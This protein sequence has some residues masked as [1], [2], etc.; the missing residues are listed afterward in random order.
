MTFYKFE[1]N[2]LLYNRIKTYPQT[3][4]V[5]YDG[6]TYYNNRAQES[7]SFTGSVGCTPPGYV[8]LYELNVDRSTEKSGPLASSLIFPFQIKNGSS[9]KFRNISTSDYNSLSFGDKMEGSY[10]QSAS[11]SSAFFGANII[12][13]PTASALQNSLNNYKVLSPSFDYNNI[14][15]SDVNFPQPSAKDMRLISIPSIFYGS[16]IR[17]GSMSLRFYVTGTLIGELKDDKKNGELR[18]T[19]AITAAGST[20]PSGSI[21]GVV[22]YNEGFII[23]TG[24]W[25]IGDSTEQYSS[26]TPNNPR[27]IDFASTSSLGASPYNS[28]PNSSFEISFEGTQYVPNLTMFATAPRGEVNFSN[29]PTALTYDPLQLG[30]IE[31]GS[32]AY[33]QPRD[34]TVKSIVSSSYSS[35]APPYEKTVFIDQIGIYDKEKNLIGIAK[36]AT[37]IRKRDND[38]LTF[39]IKLDF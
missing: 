32:F 14:T 11:I 4:F 17:K 39:K 35:P 34:Q 8:S 5:I 26:S 12:S 9:I 31:T 10:P 6:K 29:N 2:E 21:P 27:W 37:P 23:L 22:M 13:N 15:G 1:D 18:Q 16:S 30:A 33:K 7:G 20:S 36:L 19:F 28:L 3:S 38:D 24:S 25:P